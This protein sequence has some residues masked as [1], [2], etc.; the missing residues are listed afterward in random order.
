MFALLNDTLSASDN[1]G[2]VDT[3][4]MCEHLNSDA[5]IWS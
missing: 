2:S 3:K 1:S 5:F 4:L